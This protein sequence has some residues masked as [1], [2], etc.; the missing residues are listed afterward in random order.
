MSVTVQRLSH[1]AP[2]EDRLR[3]AWDRWPKSSPMQSYAWLST[4]F[5]IVPDETLA[6]PCLV[7]VRRDEEPIGLAPFYVDMNAVGMRTLRCLGDGNVCSDHASL[8]IR[9]GEEAP[10]V[11]AIAAWMRRGHGR[12]WDVVRFE[13]ID[14]EASPLRELWGKFGDEESVRLEPAAPACWT[15]ELPETV[16]QY[17]AELSR[18]HRK[19][20]RRWWREYFESGRARASVYRREE[21]ARGWDELERLNRARRETVGDRSAFLD[22]RFQRF[23]RE[24]LP[25]LATEG[26]A[27]LQG[28]TLDGRTAAVE[29]LLKHERTLYCYQSGM[30][31]TVGEGV[32]PGNLSLLAMFCRAIEEGYRRVDFLRGDESYK[33]HWNAVRR[34][35][36]DLYA[37]SA[38]W[39]GRADVLRRRAMDWARSLRRRP[40]RASHCLTA[41]AMS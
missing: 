1:L 14:A 29:Y 17:F 30:D 40:N 21:M 28:L 24:V 10:V 34:P 2:I 18:N 23:H 36:T 41:A 27:E 16:E 22:R 38:S 9:P 32:G 8:L 31:P 6:E 35:C 15:V 39:A 20:C 26:A 11:E 3:R 37:A 25:L 19:R 4:W 13:S 12:L 5:D 7:V 33:Q